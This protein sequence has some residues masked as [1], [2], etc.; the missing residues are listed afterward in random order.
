MRRTQRSDL[1]GCWRNRRA[2]GLVREVFDKGGIFERS[3]DWH[4]GILRTFVYEE[5]G[6]TM[7]EREGF[8][9]GG[10]VLRTFRFDPTGMV[11]TEGRSYGKI[12][13][14]YSFEDGGRTILE[15]DGGRYGRVVRVFQYEK[16]GISEIEGRGH[17]EPVRTFVFEKDGKAMT[18]R[19]GGW[20]GAAK[21]TFIFEGVN[22]DMLENPEIFLQFM[23]LIS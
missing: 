12:K 5:D 4:G 9:K 3:G 17:G 18:E 23:L 2:A 20:F 13:R 19:E 7:T 11:E 6:D 15:R 8:E 22:P 14:T 16:R 10:D 1:Y 21:R